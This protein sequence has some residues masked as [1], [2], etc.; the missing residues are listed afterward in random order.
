VFCSLSRTRPDFQ[1]AAR[2]ERDVGR[3][4]FSERRAEAVKLFSSLQLVL[5][6]Q[7]LRILDARVRGL[8]ALHGTTAA[9]ESES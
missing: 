7:L 8:V 3:C 1:G 5:S 4:G 2:D 6:L 9:D